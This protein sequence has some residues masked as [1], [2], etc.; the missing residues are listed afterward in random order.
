MK[1]LIA[2]GGLVT[3]VFLS[4][5]CI[6]QAGN[7]Y[8]TAG[9][10]NWSG[11]SSWTPT[12]PTFGDWA[13]INNSGTAQVT[14]SNYE[15][16]YR[17]Y[18]GENTDDM[19][20]VDVAGGSLRVTTYFYL[21]NSGKGIMNV[22]EEGS[23]SSNYCYIGNDY[24]SE[25]KATVDGVGSSWQVHVNLYVGNAGSGKLE[26]KNG[27]SVRTGKDGNIA[28]YDTPSTGEVTVT[29]SG[30]TWGIWQNLTVGGMG[31]GL[32]NI[33]DGGLVSVDGRLN[34]DTHGNAGDSSINMAGG[35]K[36]ALYG[37]A[38]DSIDDFLALVS[39]YQGT[40]AIQYWNGSAWDNITN[41]TPGVDY[42]LEYLTEG[43]LEDYTMLNVVAEVPEPSTFTM[44]IVV[45]IGFLFVRGR[46]RGR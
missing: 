1:T 21:G 4:L 27:S 43:D 46:G 13:Y 37:D 15:N 18:L 11:G 25:G 6:A 28:F 19:G 40:D 44:L 38:D 45:S 41:A 30:S 17:L 10:A 34:I 31:S 2:R 3:S 29:G 20:T 24:D 5:T 33:T 7:I 26:I 12:E 42:T 39:P 35:G 16:C 22:T 36:L 9:T 14:P 23:V 32:L 8:W